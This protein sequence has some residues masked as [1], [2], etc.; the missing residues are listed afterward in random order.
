MFTV[1][2]QEVGGETSVADITTLQ[3]TV[4]VCPP[5]DWKCD[6]CSST[7]AETDKFRKWVKPRPCRTCN[8]PMTTRRTHDSICPIFKPKGNIPSPRE[9]EA[10]LRIAVKQEPDTTC[11]EPQPSSDIPVIKTE[12]EPQWAVSAQEAT[13]KKV[14]EMTTAQGRRNMDISITEMQS[15]VAKVEPPAWKTESTWDD[16]QVPPLN[17]QS[18]VLAETIEE[19]DQAE[20]KDHT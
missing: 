12:A 14:Q 11:L 20:A 4:M 9:D 10:Y 13:Q 17:T 7:I 6:K 8:T 3:S 2:P 19:E 15:R 18:A 5:H 16:D 1:I